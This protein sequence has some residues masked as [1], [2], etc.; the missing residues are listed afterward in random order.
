[1]FEAGRIAKCRVG[2]VLPRDGFCI[3]PDADSIDPSNRVRFLVAH[4]SD[5]SGLVMGEAWVVDRSSGTITLIGTNVEFGWISGIVFQ[6]RT[7]VDYGNITAERQGENW[8]ITGL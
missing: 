6:S 5:G 2:L 4:L 1:M 8:V 7:S 3:D